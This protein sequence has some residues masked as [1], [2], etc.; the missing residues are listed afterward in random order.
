[1]TTRIPEIIS[2]IRKVYGQKELIPLHEPRFLGQEK[3]YL[4]DCID[5]TFVSSVGEYV[6]RFERMIESYTQSSHAIA[7]VNGTCALQVALELAGVKRGDEVLTQALTFVAS[8]NAI[9]YCGADPIFLDSDEDTLGMCPKSLEN[10][11][12]ENAFVDDHGVCRNRHSQK[13]ITA[14]LPIHILGHPLKIDQVSEVCQRFQI[15]VVEDAAEALGSLYQGKHAGT[16]GHLGVYSFN[17]NKTVTCGGGGVIVTNDKQL[18]KKGK[19]LTTTAKVAHPWEY[20]HDEIGYNYR[21][22]NLNAALAC[23]QMENLDRFIENKR[24]LTLIYQ[25]F[26][27]KIGIHFFQEPLGC[28]SNYWLQAILLENRKERDLFLRE[29]NQAKII[30]RPIWKLIPELSVYQNKQSSDLTQAKKISDCLINIPSSVR[31]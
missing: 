22:P 4:V 17:G 23:A 6:D 11:L 15:C 28:R 10:F 7:V 14:C 31:I 26:F 18:A 13:R 5:S 3:K 21:L 2:F 25:E 1:M 8:A 9:H 24:E 19:H 27:A 12:E 30:C 29:L 16:F 20:N